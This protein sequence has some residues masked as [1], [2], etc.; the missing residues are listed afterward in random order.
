MSLLVL[1]F[2]GTSL[3]SVE[4]IKHVAEII[5]TVRNQGHKIIVVVSAMAGTTNRLVSLCHDIISSH[6]NINSSEIDNILS[7]GETVSAGLLT[8][9]IIELGFDAISLQGWQAG[10]SSNSMHNNALITGVDNS[11]LLDLL[12]TDIIPVITGFQAISNEGRV[13]TIGRGGSDTSAAIIAASVMASSCDIYTDVEGIYTIDPRLLPSA[14]IIKQIS[15][16][17]V[18]EL[19]GTG[20][21]VLDP[22]CVEICMRYRVPLRIF[23]SFTQKSGTS[24]M[25]EVNETHKIT[26][27]SY[28]K[29]LSLVSVSDIDLDFHSF[30]QEVARAQININYILNYTDNNFVL[31]IKE[32]FE[33]RLSRVLDQISYSYCISKNI[34]SITVVGAA[35]KHDLAIMANL[36]RI[37][38]Q[39]DTKILGIAHSEI[40]VTIFCNMEGVEALV[41]NL[42]MELI[43]N[44]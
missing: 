33:E 15:F 25:N 13:T 21:K 7:T 18:I 34:A 19:A 24:I 1:K 38:N 17:E 3:G 29:N 37:F 42:H 40:K 8:L 10:I 31:S 12:N 23:S 39:F 20:A 6:N 44:A 11:K 4:R 5:R 16:A 14:Q 26:G 9:A 41:Q 2:G 32:E 28:F 43:E 36:V 35:L 30:I 22:R 27:I